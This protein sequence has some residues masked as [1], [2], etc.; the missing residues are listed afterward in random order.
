[1]IVL[2][3]VG[4]PEY[5]ITLLDYFLLYLEMK[6]LSANLP[7]WYPYIS[8]ICLVMRGNMACRGKFYQSI[9]QGLLRLDF[10]FSALV[11]I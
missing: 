5:S 8:S 4:P 7:N 2:A 11:S 6:L 3:T 9:S 10:Y 1:M